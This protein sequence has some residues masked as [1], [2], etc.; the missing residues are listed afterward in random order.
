MTELSDVIQHIHSHA[1]E[2]ESLLLKEASNLK[3]ADSAENIEAVAIQKMDLVQ[4]LDQ[5][6]LRRRQLIDDSSDSDQHDRDPVWQ[7]TLAIL[8]RCQMLNNQAGADITVQ[9]RYKQRALEILGT[10]HAETQL[11][12]ASGAAQFAGPKQA[13]GKA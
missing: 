11:Y 13:L 4:A 10:P 3:R 12:S 8:S 9:S 2:L 1:C 6:A 5:L 7:D